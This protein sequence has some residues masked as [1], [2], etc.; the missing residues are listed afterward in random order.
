MNEQS[1]QKAT[2]FKPLK[3]THMHQQN[4]KSGSWNM[5][6]LL[7]RLSL[8]KVSQKLQPSPFL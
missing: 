3:H 5:C 8:G 6:T 1:F 2:W 4:A 7:V